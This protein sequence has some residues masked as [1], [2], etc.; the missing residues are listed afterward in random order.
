MSNQAVN[1]RAREHRVRDHLIGHGWRIVM[2]AAGS[3]GAADLLMVHG[4]HGGALVQVGTANKRLGPA[5]RARF[6]ADATDL[7]CLPLVAQV[8]QGVGIRY[9]H[10]NNGVPS[11]WTEWKP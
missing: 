3:R 9:W 8:I 4:T 2:R 5:D 11:T 6:T 10:A 7:G 1:G